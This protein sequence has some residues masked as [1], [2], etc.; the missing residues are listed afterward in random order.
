M[1]S[2][3]H[4]MILDIIDRYKIDTQEELA[5]RLKEQGV[6]VTQATV[7]RDIKELRLIKVLSD[8]G[9]Y[10]YATVDKAE[11][12]LK[13]RFISIFAHSVVS[14]TMASG[15]III[16]TIAGTAGSAC[17]T[18]DSLHWEEVAGTIAG[19]NTI[20]VAVKDGVDAPELIH[21]FQA[22]IKG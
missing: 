1:K 3:R 17:E 14:M 9:A 7:S 10:K 12:G 2:A 20:F 11:A 21:R 8:D 5:S 19:E 6:Q 4:T 13:D 18:I 16:K 22:L 15:L